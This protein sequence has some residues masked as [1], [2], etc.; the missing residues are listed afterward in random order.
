MVAFLKM[1]CKEN[2]VGPHGLT[3]FLSGGEI[4]DIWMEKDVETVK[5]PVK[6]L[7]NFI[8]LSNI[9]KTPKKFIQSVLS[10]IQECKME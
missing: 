5:V 8:D 9:K 10:L 3:E 6:K 7:I 1:Y 4:N 2:G